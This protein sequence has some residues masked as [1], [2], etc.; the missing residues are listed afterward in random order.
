MQELHV[1]TSAYPQ[2]YITHAFILIIFKALVKWP[3]D[4]DK[5]APTDLR[6]LH[7]VL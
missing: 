4:S 7:L 6:T 3:A 2:V 5:L 1:Y